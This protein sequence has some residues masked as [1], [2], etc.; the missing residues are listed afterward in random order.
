MEAARR[1][2]FHASRFNAG[3]LE[4]C[5]EF[6]ELFQANPK[7]MNH[8]GNPEQQAQ[9]DVDERGFHVVGLEKNRQRRNEQ[10]KDDE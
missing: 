2:R 7:R 9:H 1:C 4:P 6:P 10:G 3:E 5:A 8:A